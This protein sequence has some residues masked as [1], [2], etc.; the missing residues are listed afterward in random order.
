M[1]FSIVVAASIMWES[2]L[3]KKTFLRK[4]EAHLK[5]NVLLL[6]LRW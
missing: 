6:H 4:V 2:S 1:L 3:G 5:G